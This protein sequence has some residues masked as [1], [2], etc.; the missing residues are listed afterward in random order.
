MNFKTLP[1]A[2][3]A[4][5]LMALPAA[6]AQS[7]GA[8][9][10]LSAADAATPLAAGGVVQIEIDLSGFKSMDLLGSALNQVVTRNIGANAQVVGFGYS[11]VLS[12]VF[13]SYFSEAEI[14][15]N[16]TL[17]VQPALG[18]DE[19]G[20]GEVFSSGG[21]VDLVALGDEFNVGASGELR[22]EL[23][24]TYDD[25][26]GLADLSYDVGSKITVQYIAAIP[27]PASYA[28]L[29]LGLVAVGCMKRRR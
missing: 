26:P 17:L 20:S 7:S 24:E 15:A 22:I 9:V 11:L 4:S 10:P 27:E 2:L 1:L 21:I 12:T 6:Q 8:A 3:A 14:R 16:N 29:A 13:P 19:R 23:Y 25:L 18:V 5:A 28:L